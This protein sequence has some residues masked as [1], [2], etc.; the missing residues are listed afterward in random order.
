MG[1][2]AP[3]SSNTQRNLAIQE[4][5]KNGQATYQYETNFIPG[6]GNIADPEAYK[7]RFEQQVTNQ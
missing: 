2:A 5:L 3:V 6:I 7:K 1:A 4:A